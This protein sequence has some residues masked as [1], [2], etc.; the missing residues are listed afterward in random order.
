M[1]TPV[2]RIPVPGRRFSHIHLDLVGPLPSC[3][4]FSYLLMMI[5]RTSWWPE[6]RDGDYG[7]GWAGEH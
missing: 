4:R 6:K 5:D 3:Q 2:L 7:E 1:K